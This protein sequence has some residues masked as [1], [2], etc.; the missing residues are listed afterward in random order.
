MINTLVFKWPSSPYCID[1][2][3]LCDLCCQ[4][5]CWDTNSNGNE[6][7]YEKEI[8]QKISSSEAMLKLHYKFAISFKSI[9]ERS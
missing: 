2:L 5:R 8:K 4:M 9:F 1:S 6:K 7:K 3:N